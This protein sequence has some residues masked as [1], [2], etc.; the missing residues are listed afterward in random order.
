MVGKILNPNCHYIPSAKY[1]GDTH[2]S[3]A[4]H[5]D[6]WE[7]P[8]CRADPKQPEC[9]FNLKLDKRGK[10]WKCR[11]CKKSLLMEMKK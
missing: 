11:F 3:K 7:C 2:S 8:R 1:I 6:R 10:I 9:R 5:L 4:Q